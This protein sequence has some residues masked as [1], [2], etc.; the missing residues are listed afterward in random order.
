[1][2]HIDKSN[3]N[4]VIKG[5][6]FDLDGVLVDTA[7]YHYKAW[8]KLANQ[9]GFDFTEAQNEELK[10]I[11]RMESLAKILHWG[12]IEKTNGEQI[13][14]ATQKN[15]WYLEM[16]NKMTPSEVLP[17]VVNYLAELKKAGYKLALGSASKNASIILQNT[18]LTAFFD[19]IVDGNMVE[20]SKPNPEVFLKG[21]ELLGLKPHQCVVYEDAAAGIEAAV[22]AKM[23]SIGI[24]EKEILNKANLV[25]SGID[26][27]TIA[28]LKEI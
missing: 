1:M 19:Q 22:N 16:I 27:L 11:S 9:L 12:G 23:K 25:V 7:G 20:H 17:G 13:A 6:L 5:C 4:T 8:R 18:N 10:G 14:L 3:N 2:N 21:A 26:K 24:G 28:K 15:G